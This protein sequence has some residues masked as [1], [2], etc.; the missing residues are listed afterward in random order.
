MTELNRRQFL[1]RAAL[2]GAGIGLGALAVGCNSGGGAPSCNDTSGMAPAD[3]TTRTA[4]G[5]VDRSTIA[6]KN[7]A[8]CSLFTAGGEGQCGSCTVVRG[9]IAAEGYCNLWVA[10]A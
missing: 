2:I 9:P 6:A 5:Y 4:N 8:N 10:A 3:I 7:C 1:E